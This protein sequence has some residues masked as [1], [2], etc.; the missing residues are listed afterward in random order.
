MTLTSITL[1]QRE[2]VNLSV[3]KIHQAALKSKVQL[4]LLAKFL[5]QH[6]IWGLRPVVIEMDTFD[7]CLMEFSLSLFP[8]YSGP[9]PLHKKHEE[10]KLINAHKSVTIEVK[11]F[12]KMQRC[13]Q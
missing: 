12:C 5:V 10:N 4:H 1:A 9:M 6:H 7:E 11:L 2:S 3:Y 13:M 8:N